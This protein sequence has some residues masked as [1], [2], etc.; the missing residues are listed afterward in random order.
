MKYNSHKCLGYNIP[1]KTFND[2]ANIITGSED[3]DIFIY[4]LNTGEVVN[5]LRCP[6]PSHVIH[7][8]EATT[9]S[10]QIKIVSSSIEE[11]NILRWGPVKTPEREEPKEKEPN[12]EDEF[13]STQRAIIETLMSKYG[14]RILELF[15]K[16]NVTFSSQMDSLSIQ[17]ILLSNDN[18]NVNSIV[19]EISEDFARALVENIDNL[20]NNNEFTESEEPQVR[21]IDEEGVGNI[22]MNKKIHSNERFM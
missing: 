18:E 16:K 11:L 12:D 19:E 1:A 4:D 17:S 7:I 22:T 15:H 5:Q 9:S 3:K 20:T 8:A 6:P 2:E 13:F 21:E 14:D 10:S